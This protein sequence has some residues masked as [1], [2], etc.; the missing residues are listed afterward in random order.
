MKRTVSLL[1]ITLGLATYGAACGGGNENTGPVTP[2]P[3]ATGPSGS[4]STTSAT[5]SASSTGGTEAPKPS[6]AEQWKKVAGAMTAAWAAHD[7]KAAGATYTDTAMVGAPGAKGWEEIKATE[8][9][10]KLQGFFTAAPDVKMTVVRSITKD[11]KAAIEWH[12]AGTNTGEMMGE[13]ATGKKFAQ[14]GLSVLTLD[15]ASGKI[16]HESLYM[17]DT[18]MMGQLGKAPPGVKF[19]AA[20]AA[21]AGETEM[22]MAKDGE[23]TS[24]NEAA[25]KAVYASFE[26]KDEKAFLAGMDDNCVWADYAQPADMKG[27]DAAKKFFGEWSK[28]FPDSK[29]TTK[30]MFAAGDWVVVEA[31]MTGT[32]KGPLGGGAVKPTGKSAT[33]HAADVIKLKDGKAVMGSTYSN[34]LEF[35]VLYGLMP[36]PKMGGAPKGPDAKPGDAKKPDTKPADTTKPADKPPTKK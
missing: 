8:A 34:G 15:K 27:K 3:S 31:E 33:T 10:Q 32:F 25:V 4:A 6:V 5:P 12:V 18:T 36:A 26:K 35:A 7:A 13:K 24:K 20:D 19:R 29:M 16:S 28:A 23:D 22:I 21:P 30:S 9:M 14:H 2:P 17:D 1:A 11:D